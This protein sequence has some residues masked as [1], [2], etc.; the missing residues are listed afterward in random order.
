MSMRSILFAGLLA[1]ASLLL[2]TPADAQ[3]RPEADVNFLLGFPQGEMRENVDNVGFGLNLFGG[4]G[5]QDSPVVL[6]AELGLMIYGF[7]R[8]R[9]P[10]SNTIP[11]VTVDVETSNNVVMGHLVLRMQPPTGAVRPYLDGLFGFKY[12]FTQ[13]SVESDRFGDQEPIAT[14]TN[15]DD[16]ALSYG[17]GGGLK[18][19]VWE[20]ALQEGR[21]GAVAINVGVRYLFGGEAEYL[22]EGSIRRTNGSVTFDVDRSETDLLVVLIGAS[23]RF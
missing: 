23:L 6:G 21:P 9:E 3:V 7:E 2:S 17:V 16:A 5:L 11:D 12:F 19:T 15:F 18:A 13:T 8:R 20:G 1:G 4:V 10:F 14:S 22:Q